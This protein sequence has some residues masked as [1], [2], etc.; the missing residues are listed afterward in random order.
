MVLG[1]PF[2]V[3]STILSTW[4][5]I[6]SSWRLLPQAVASAWSVG[7]APIAAAL[8][9]LAYLSVPSASSESATAASTAPQ[10]ATVTFDNLV[11]STAID[12]PAAVF[13]QPSAS[14]DLLLESVLIG[15]AASGDGSYVR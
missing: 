2:V 11:A 15:G 10:A 12:T 4:I 13:L 5:R 9:L 8:V 6:A 1:S 14:G 7:L 3:R